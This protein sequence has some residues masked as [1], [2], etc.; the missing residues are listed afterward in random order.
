MASQLV[1][2]FI[3]THPLAVMMSKLNTKS[4]KEK[5]TTGEDT[6][7]MYIYVWTTE[8]T[9][10]SLVMIFAIYV[11]WRRHATFGYLAAIFV[12]QAYLLFALL[13]DRGTLGGLFPPRLDKQ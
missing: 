3:S 2:K 5:M 10:Q 7:E 13:T 9:I 12:P 1:E 6:G 8:T 11:A 4:K